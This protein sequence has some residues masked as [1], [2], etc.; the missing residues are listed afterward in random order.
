MAFIKSFFNESLGL[1]IFTIYGIVKPDELL[2]CIDSYYQGERANL[3]LFDFS[4]ATLQGIHTN[5]RQRKKNASDR[6][7][8]NSDR[9]A[10]VF[11]SIPEQELEPF[12][13]DYCQI[14][15]HDSNLGVFQNLMEASR[16]LLKS[17]ATHRQLV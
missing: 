14:E 2:K 13:K 1:R 8:R 16:W 5:P 10:F 11:P 9:K 3:V 6:Y 17:Q 7:T 12:L 4:D 15:Q